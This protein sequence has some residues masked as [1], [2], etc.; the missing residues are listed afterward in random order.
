MTG[1]R[2]ARQATSTPAAMMIRPPST[3]AAC[4]VPAVS[5]AREWKPATLGRSEAPPLPAFPEVVEAPEPVAGLRLAGR[6]RG[7]AAAAAETPARA[8][9]ARPAPRPASSTPTARRAMPRVASTATR[10]A[11]VAMA[12]PS[13]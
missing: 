4:Q 13:A 3:V 7:R 6:G 9:A 8:A 10:L 12:R 11:S 1:S 5:T 2:A